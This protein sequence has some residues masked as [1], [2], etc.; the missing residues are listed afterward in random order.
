MISRGTC[1][2]NLGSQAMCN[3]RQETICIGRKIDSFDALLEIED[4][5]DESGILMTE[6]I[7]FLTSPSRCFDIVERSNIFAPF[8]FMCHLDEFRI[9]HHHSM[10]NSKESLVRWE[11]A[12]STSQR[13]SCCQIKEFM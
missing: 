5:P 3:C 1:E 4:C 8:T 11:N 2:E 12:R 13:V 10:Y 7:V 6:S 9:L